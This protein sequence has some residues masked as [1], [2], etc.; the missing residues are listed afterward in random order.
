MTAGLRSQRLTKQMES[1]YRKWI[2]IEE[3]PCNV[4]ALNDANKTAFTVR[5]EIHTY[6]VTQMDTRAQKMN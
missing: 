4:P 3:S 6:S 5:R 1:Y 2:M